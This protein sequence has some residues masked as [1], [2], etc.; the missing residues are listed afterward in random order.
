MPA[1]ES[2]RTRRPSRKARPAVHSSMAS[3]LRTPRSSSQ[4]CCALRSRR[5][6]A[7]RERT[8]HWRVNTRR[9]SPLSRSCDG[10]RLTHHWQRKPRR[11]LPIMDCA[12]RTPC[13]PPSRRRMDVISS[14]STKNIS[15]AWIPCCGSALRYKPWPP[16]KLATPILQIGA[17]LNREQ[18]PVKV[19]RDAYR[20][21]DRARAVRR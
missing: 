2:T 10:F 13:M 16:D 6:S 20:R 12:A 19:T 4:R 9:S 18:N 7:G 21:Q 11:S 3:S 17:A 14:R 1:Y 8:L 15:P 5:Q